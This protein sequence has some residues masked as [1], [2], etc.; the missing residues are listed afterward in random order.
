MDHASLIMEKRSQTL[1]ER[2]MKVTTNLD[3]LLE[4]LSITFNRYATNPD[5]SVCFGTLSIPIKQEEYDSTTD[6]FCENLKKVFQSRLLSR[7]WDDVKIQSV[8]GN[9]QRDYRDPDL[10]SYQIHVKFDR[11]K[12]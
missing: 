3:G 12:W 11:G 9:L 5:N 2:Q 1:Q 4:Q 7:G 8:E 10:I 6:D